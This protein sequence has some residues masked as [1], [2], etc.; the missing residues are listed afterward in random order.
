MVAEGEMQAAILSAEV[1]LHRLKEGNRS[2]FRNLGFLIIQN[3]RQQILSVIHHCHNLNLKC[4]HSV[5]CER[6]GDGGFYIRLRNVSI[7]G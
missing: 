4:L 2:S 7:V 3:F 1:S 6:S 5:A